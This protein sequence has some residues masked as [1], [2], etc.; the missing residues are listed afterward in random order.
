MN[1][2]ALHVFIGPPTRAS[3]EVW[4]TFQTQ[5]GYKL[6]FKLIPTESYYLV[7]EMNLILKISKTLKVHW[8]DVKHANS[9]Q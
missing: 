9:L 8:D 2:E 4:A 6:T 3:P 7:N 5:R 1:V